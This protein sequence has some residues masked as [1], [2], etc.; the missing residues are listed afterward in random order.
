MSQFYLAEV[1]IAKRLAPMD[2]PIM[3][4]FVDN[5]DRINAI[6]DDAEGFVWRMQN[7]DKDEG[8]SIFQDDTLII[9]MSIWT[10]LEALFNYTY[11]SGHIE[12]FKRKKEWFSKLKMMHMAFWYV[13]KDYEPTFKD[14]KIRLDYLNTYGDTPFA[15]SFKK[16]FSVEDALK[17]KQLK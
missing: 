10:N 15:F 7:E 1:N 11:K 17:Y 13:P 4:D 5:I 12:V 9:N 6:A 2:D 8:A 16:K 3:K 14:A